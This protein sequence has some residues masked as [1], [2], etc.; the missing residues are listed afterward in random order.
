MNENSVHD[1]MK[2]RTVSNSQDIVARS[3][4][5][6]AVASAAVRVASFIFG[7][8]FPNATQKGS[9]FKGWGPGVQQVT[10]DRG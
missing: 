2:L 8:F 4:N 3:K 10:S 6:V 9:R 5:K 1:E 7:R